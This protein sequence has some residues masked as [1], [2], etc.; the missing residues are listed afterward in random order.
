MARI[1]PGYPLE[2]SKSSPVQPNFYKKLLMERPGY[3][4]LYWG[5]PSV[6]WNPAQ[7]LSR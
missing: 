4:Y 5:D 1:T 3:R 2:R 7:F 6:R